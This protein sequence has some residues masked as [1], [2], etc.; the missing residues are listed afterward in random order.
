MPTVGRFLGIN[1]YMYVSDH[2]PPHVH[3]YS[4]DD[5]CK[6]DI[7]SGKL[8]SGDLDSNKLKLVQDFIEIYKEELIMM[9]NT[10]RI[11]KISK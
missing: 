6:I 5:K 7:N 4:G 1:I 10:K 2:E 8:I 3:V 9:W 11:H